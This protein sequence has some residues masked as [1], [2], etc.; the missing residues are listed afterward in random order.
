MGGCEVVERG[1]EGVWDGRVVL[2]V[3]FFIILLYLW[4]RGRNGR[5]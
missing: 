3:F 2:V 5:L 1:R 4:E